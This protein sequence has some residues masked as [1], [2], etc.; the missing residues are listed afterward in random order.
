MMPPQDKL[1][2]TPGPLTTSRGVKDAMLHDVGSRDADFVSVVREIRQGLLALA[3]VGQKDGYEAILV[4]G[5]G[6]FGIESV[7]SSVIPSGG[8]LLIIIN[9]AYGKRIRDIAV[10]LGIETAVIEVKENT[11]SDPEQVRRSLAGDREITHV[12]LVHCETS[13]G[14]LNPLNAI[15]AVVK[16][17]GRTFIVDAMSSFGGMPLDMAEAGIDFLASSAN[18]CIESVPGISLVIADREKLLASSGCSRSISLDL[19]AQWKGLEDTGQFRFTPPTHAILAFRQALRELDDEGGAVGR[20]NRYAANHAALLRG[21][22]RMGFREYVPTESQSHIITTFLYPEDPNF[23]FRVFYQRL[24]DKGMVIYPGKLT[25]VDCFRI[26]NIGRIFESD[27]ASLVTAIK[28]TL[29]EMNMKIPDQNTAPQ[30]ETSP[31]VEYEDYNS[32]SGSYDDTRV[33]VGLPIVLDFLASTSTALSEQTVLDAGCGTGTCLA[34]LRG[35]IGKLHGLELNTGMQQVAKD[36]FADDPDVQVAQ[37]SITELGFAD[38]T[39][40][41]V[42]CNQVLHHLDHGGD[43]DADADGF[44]NVQLFFHEAFRVLQP[45]GVVVINTSSHLQHREGFWWAPLIPA[46]IDRMLQRFPSIENLESAA[47]QAGFVGFETVV[48]V[49]EALQGEQYLNPEGPLSEAWRAG[50]STWSLATDEELSSAIDDVTTRTEN[51]GMAA[52]L[53]AA[54]QRRAEIGQTTFLAVRKP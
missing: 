41:G 2:F 29:M 46:A 24:S 21:M 13:S 20:A 5:A 53:G 3:G 33:P 40:N 12:A 27:I 47:R 42:V 39:F 7:I 34:E 15:G 37:G 31:A 10:R 26:G 44:P 52:F 4:Q 6:T 16:E 50:D 36:R 43:E 49:A 45:G 9:G 48:P 22:R 11:P 54:E 23:E 19:L 25:E 35:Q 18:K 14:V 32:T 30:T 1:L 8:K 28:E 38:G 17:S 51:G